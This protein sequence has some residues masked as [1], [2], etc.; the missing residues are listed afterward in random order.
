MNNVTQYRP[1]HL[2]D[3][4]KLSLPSD[5]PEQ[6]WAEMHTYL[7]A[8]KRKAKALILESYEFGAAKYGQE[9]AGR[10]HEQAELA[11]GLPKKATKADVNGEG[12][13]KGFISVEGISQ[14]FSIWQR[15]VSH[16]I[17]TWEPE[18]LSRALELLEPIEQQAQAI[19]ARLNDLRV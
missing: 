10:V 1:I 16:L 6:H 13:A 15:S 19:R 11:L 8:V 5:M 9:V 17:P 4:F 18:R 14:S 3:D 2:T 7:V 12:K